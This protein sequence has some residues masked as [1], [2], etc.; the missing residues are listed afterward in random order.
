MVCAIILD[1]A[2]T[3]WGLKLSAHHSLQ[4]QEHQLVWRLTSFQPRRQL[5][6]DNRAP[7]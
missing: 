1:R 2:E 3:S 6:H 4:Q 7:L 5:C